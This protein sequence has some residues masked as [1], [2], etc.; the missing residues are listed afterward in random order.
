MIQRHRVA[1]TD[2]D[3]AAD[4]VIVGKERQPLLGVKPARLDS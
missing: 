3:I 2:G 1:A 4:T